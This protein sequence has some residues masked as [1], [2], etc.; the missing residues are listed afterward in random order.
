MNYRYEEGGLDPIAITSLNR[1]HSL[2]KAFIGLS[3][4]SELELE[5]PHGLI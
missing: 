3:W 5:H 4:M 1:H 2:N